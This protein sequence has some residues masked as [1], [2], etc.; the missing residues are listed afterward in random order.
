MDFDRTKKYRDQSGDVWSWNPQTEWGYVSAS[1]GNKSV[2]W[3]APIKADDTSYTEISEK[4]YEPGD[5]LKNDVGKSFLIAKDGNAYELG[6]HPAGMRVP[7]NGTKP[8]SDVTHVNAVAV[9]RPN[10]LDKAEV[11]DLAS[12]GDPFHVSRRIYVRLP[13]GWVLSRVGPNTAIRGVLQGGNVGAR[14]YATSELPS[15]TKLVK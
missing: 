8:F 12:S 11:G 2:H 14:V 13:D 9:I 1:T 10:P 7:G 4:A 15:D 5:L 6:V 3:S